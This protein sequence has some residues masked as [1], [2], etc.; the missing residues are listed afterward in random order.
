MPSAAVQHDDRRQALVRA[1][2]SHRLPHVAAE[3]GGPAARA[4]CLGGQHSIIHSAR[5]EHTLS[6]GGRAW[7]AFR[8][9]V[10]LKKAVLS[11]SA[12]DVN[13][14][15]HSRSHIQTLHKSAREGAQGRVAALIL[16]G[17]RFGATIMRHAA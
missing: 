5:V 7:K 14:R 17:R 13:H 12:S 2:G 9:S 1:R 3:V 6:G 8:A 16:P 10:L 11:V 4:S 15:D